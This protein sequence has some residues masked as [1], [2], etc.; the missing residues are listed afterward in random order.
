MW[1]DQ[2][3]IAQCGET[4]ITLHSVE[5]PTLHCGSVERP[6][7]QCKVWRGQHYSAK[8]GEDITLHSVEIPTLLQCT[9]QR[10]QHYIASVERR[11]YNSVWKVWKDGHDTQDYFSIKTW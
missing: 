2:Q 5:R 7:L 10:D 8:C 6:T 11:H 3:Y 4:N 9:V 1:R